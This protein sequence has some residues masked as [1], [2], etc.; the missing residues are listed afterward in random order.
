MAD[1]RPVTRDGARAILTVLLSPIAATSCRAARSCRSGKWIS[2][3][4]RVAR[5]SIA[6]RLADAAALAP[7]LTCARGA[8]TAF[9][10]LPTLC[11]PNE[12]IPPS[13]RMRSV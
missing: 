7:A 8:G 9:Y 5:I 11:D 10:L 1:P 2:W 4:W 6:E 12:P 13:A 3:P